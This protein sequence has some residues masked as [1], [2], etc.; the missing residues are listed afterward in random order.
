MSDRFGHVIF[1]EKTKSLSVSCKNAAER[2]EKEIENIPFSRG[3]NMALTK[4]E[5]CMM[6]VN[7]ALREAQL[8][9]NNSEIVA[10]VGPRPTAKQAVIIRKA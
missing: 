3:K 9:K 7:K 5:E 10:K 1:D 8:D 4:L 6:W 2:L